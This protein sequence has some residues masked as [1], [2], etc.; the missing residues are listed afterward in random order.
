MKKTILLSSV[1]ALA[2]VSFASDS[3]LETRLSAME[4]KVKKLEKKLKK[5]HK[6]LKKTNKKLNIVK[7]H[8]A[9]DNIKWDVDFRTTVDNI[10]YDLA[11]G[12]TKKNSSLLTNRLLLN[13][14]TYQ[15]YF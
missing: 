9:G 3:D 11:N 2:T 10:N 7:A 12:T 5:D 8:D 13:M 6:K 15:V 4:K 14:K 1:V